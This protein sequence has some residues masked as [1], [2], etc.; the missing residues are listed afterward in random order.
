MVRKVG[1]EV[2]IFLVLFCYLFCYVFIDFTNLSSLFHKVPKELLNMN[3]IFISLFL[4]ALPFVLIGIIVS[5]II[6]V[7]V[8]PETISKILPKNALL[9][10]IPVALIGMIMPVCECGIVPIVRSLLKKGMPA[11]IGIVFLSSVPI[12]NPIVFTST[13]YA[14]QSNSQMA[15]LRLGLAFIVVLI[16]GFFTLLFYRNKNVLLETRE[17][18]ENHKHVHHIHSNTNRI[19][20]VISHISSEFFSTCKFLII[21]GLI[22]SVFQTFLDRS[23]LIHLSNHTNLSS[24]VMMGLGYFLS[25][26][27]GSDAFIAAS[28]S[29]TFHVKSILAFL[30]FGA[31]IDLKN[32]FMMFAYFKKRFVF[33][34]IFLTASVVFVVT[35]IWNLYW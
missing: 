27:S 34:Y 24:M 4:E 17:K 26:C 28:F 9:A 16:I 29:S 25:L 35:S 31:M 13:Y 30:I 5:S 11:Y 21:G 23:V 7:F 6:H 33:F 18:H 10:F 19:S 1:Q 8:K 22:T 12:I 2:I 15:F 20:E 32:T 3:T 14:F